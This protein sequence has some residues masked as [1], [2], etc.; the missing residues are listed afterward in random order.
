MS[1]DRPPRV[2]T[3]ERDGEVGR[4]V[5]DRPRP[6]RRDGE[7]GDRHRMKSGAAKSVP[8]LL[9]DLAEIGRLHRYVA[10]A[11][12]GVLEIGYGLAGRSFGPHGSGDT[13]SVE[14]A[15]TELG[16]RE[17][18]AN[19]AVEITRQVRAAVKALEAAQRLA[20]KVEMEKVADQARI[21]DANALARKKAGR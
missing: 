14:S 10:D 15:V 13:S 8:A 17:R 9:E 11:Y 5:L 18:A 2:V 4:Q 19:A 3:W 16:E 12:P 21:R 7:E 20:E 1:D 6:P